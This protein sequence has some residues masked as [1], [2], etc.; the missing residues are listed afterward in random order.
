MTA[1][2]LSAAEA[3][4][5]QLVAWRRDLHAHPELGFQEL[6]T[7]GIVAETLGKLGYEVVTGVGH[8]G[9]VGLLPGGKPG[10]QTVLLRFDM[11]ALP[12]DEANDVPYRSVTPGVMH[13]CGHDAHVAIG[14]GVATIL[15]RHQAEFPGTI[16]LMF[17]PAEEIL[18][19][20]QSM[21]DA[22]LLSA[23]TVDVALGLHVSSN[24]PTGAAVVRSGP[25]MAAADVLTIQ[26]HGRGGHA[27]H[28]EQ[29]ID[30]VLVAA[31]IVV[32]LQ[33]IVARN[34][35]PLDTGVITVASIHAGTA[36]NVIAETA[37]LTGSIRSFTEPTRALLHRRVHEI[38]T[39][40]ATAF[41]A[42]ADVTIER[43]VDPTVNAPAPTAVVYGAA[44]AVFGPD[45]IDTT[46]RTTGGEDFS[47][48][49]SRVPGNFFFLGARNE[50]RGITAPH[51]NAHFDI[52]EACLPQGV[53]VLC[54]AAIRCL[55]GELKQAGT[56]N[57]D[58]TRPT[59]A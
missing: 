49:L 45:Q 11:D 37:T 25:M 40:V 31:Q 27:A 21:I 44:S 43:G 5:D 13:A 32:A 46:Y 54:D 52:D 7:A 34:I 57:L 20:A 55:N 10:D 23:P 33:T 58:P 36:N 48:V 28:P 15:A 41:G 16:K 56:S 18:N 39:G 24:H 29:A 42:R 47:A 38:A 1:P 12:I 8:T 35:D 4:Q 17:Q 30:A 26:I 19:G 51:H 50:A 59:D 2:F 6:R 3:M 22:G 53:A 9:V 14:L